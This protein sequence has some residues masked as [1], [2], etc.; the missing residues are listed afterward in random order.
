MFNIAIDK[1][2]KQN[3]NNGDAWNNWQRLMQK[4]AANQLQNLKPTLSPAIKQIQE[5][6][7][8]LS[9]HQAKEIKKSIKPLVD[10][11]AESAQIISKANLKNLPAFQALLETIAKEV[12]ELPEYVDDVHAYLARQG[13]FVP[14]R[15]AHLSIFKE[16]SILIRN[17]EHERIEQDLQV[18]ITENI[19]FIKSSVQREY[20]NRLN[21][22]ALAIQAHEKEEYVLSIPTLL[23]Q[24]DGMFSE[25][26][27]KTFYSNKKSDLEDIRRRLLKR[28]AKKNHPHNTSSLGYLLIKQLKEKSIIHEDFDE[29]EKNKKDSFNKNPLNRN[30]ILHG[31]D[32]LYGT[33]ANS[34]R[35]ISLIGLL[36]DC[37]KTLTR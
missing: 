19:P 31:K 10:Q 14:F 28:L 4:I 29:F 7:K 36:A 5:T 25:L 27:D 20:P 8:Q 21:I 23:A 30:Y 1:M 37:K 32:L 9:E 24:A 22:I 33:K 3:K 35:T 26:I 34:L 18:F 16:Y 15:M 2:T 12:K 11:F 13:W 6:V 17:E